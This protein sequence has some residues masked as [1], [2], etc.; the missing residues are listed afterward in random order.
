[1]NAKIQKW[2]NS[3]G[4][5]IPQEIRKK[6]NINT[7]DSFNIIVD[8]LNRIVLEKVENENLIDKLFSKYEHKEKQ[9]ELEWGQS[10]GAEIW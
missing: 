6:L 10:V 8:D 5:R 9:T 1:M 7:D 4:V 3:F 2:G